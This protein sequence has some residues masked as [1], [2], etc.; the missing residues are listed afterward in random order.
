MGVWRFLDLT[1]GYGRVDD[2]PGETNFRKN[3]LND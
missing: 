3:S 1:F 2:A